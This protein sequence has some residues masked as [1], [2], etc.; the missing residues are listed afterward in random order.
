MS[1]AQSQ[2]IQTSFLSSTTENDRDHEDEDA[3]E[4]DPSFPLPKFYSTSF[5]AHR[6]SPLYLGKEGRLTNKRLRTLAQRLRDVLVG[7]VVRGVEVGLDGQDSLMGRY[8]A[9]ERVGIRWVGLAQVLDIDLDGASQ[10][11][12]QRPGSR[13]LGIANDD[14]DD[15]DHEGRGRS[16]WKAARILR[17]L[18]TQNNGNKRKRVLH[19][20]LEYENAGCTALLFP[21]LPTSGSGGDGD[22]SGEEQNDQHMQ[23]HIGSN[24][25]PGKGAQQ[26]K[27]FLNMPLL[28]LRM[29]APLKGVIAEFLST[30]FDCRVSAL[31]LGTRSMV[32]GLEGW[33]RN[34]GTPSRGALAK[35]VVFFL[36]FHLPFTSSRSSAREGQEKPGEVE[37]EEKEEEAEEAGLGV[38]SIDITIPAAEVGRFVDAGRGLL[39]QQEKNKRKSTSTSTSSQN[40]KQWGWEVDLRKRR[41]IAGRLYEEGWEWRSDKHNS[42]SA[43]LEG[44]EQEEE[45]A[46]KEEDAFTEALG[47]Y[48]DRHMGLNLF[49]PGVRV[50]KIACGGFVMSEGRVKVFAPAANLGEGHG[51]LSGGQGGAVLELLAG[52]V[53]KATVRV[54]RFLTSTTGTTT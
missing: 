35:D 41:K 43:L 50:T 36:G 9:L 44:Q 51:S 42:A 37:E 23:F 24:V 25:N 3:E 12:G 26:E 6:V 13:D 20:Q 30:S 21:E 46:G 15:D 22:I 8:G 54:G 31:R 47:R 5:S 1:P 10:D 2:S 49:H 18:R 48:V 53:E 38:K 28:L 29:P 45:N 39:S 27:K 4:D 33:F 7:D 32:S 52:L 40:E 11:E 34:V 16:S 14:N 17:E 19:I